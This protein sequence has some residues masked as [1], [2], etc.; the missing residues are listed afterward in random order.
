MNE[1][2][3]EKAAKIYRHIISK[4]SKRL[5]KKAAKTNI[6]IMDYCDADG[7]IIKLVAYRHHDHDEFM[8]NCWDKFRI[9]INKSSHAYHRESTYKTEKTK[10]ELPKTINTIEPCDSHSRGAEP[11]TVGMP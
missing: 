10:G 5:T 8:K 7:K 2:T 9:H 11:I 3:K 6:T 4:T 1:L